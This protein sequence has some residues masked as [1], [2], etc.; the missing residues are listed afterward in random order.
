VT[1]IDTFYDKEEFT[2]DMIAFTRDTYVLNHTIQLET[3]DDAA[4]D[5]LNKWEKVIN[6]YNDLRKNL[7]PYLTDV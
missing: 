4:T 3:T 2:G 5:Y 1:S 6:D 7:P